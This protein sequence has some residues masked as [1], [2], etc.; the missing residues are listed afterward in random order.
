[1]K[2]I[3]ESSSARSLN[4]A[5][6]V[7]GGQEASAKKT[8]G[9]CKY[10]GWRHITADDQNFHQVQW[11]GE[12]I[13]FGLQKLSSSAIRRKKINFNANRYSR[14]IFHAQHELKKR[15][16][17]RRGE[18]H[19]VETIGQSQAHTAPYNPYGSQIAL[20]GASP[21]IAEFDSDFDYEFELW[22]HR[23][24]DFEFDYEFEFRFH[25]EFDFDFCYEFEF[26]FHCE[27]DFEFDGEFEFRFHC[28]SDFDFN[29]EFELWFI[30][31]MT[32]SLTSSSIMSLSYD[33]IMSLTS[34]SIMSL[35]FGFI[36]NFDFKFDSEFEFRFHCEYDLEFD[37]HIALR[38]S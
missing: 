38:V 6:V 18:V 3:Q 30:V 11:K 12:R 33:F 25:C 34:S 32:S 20:E 27:F 29:Y 2:P 36:V 28:E 4:E 22:F 15:E 5:P 24:F 16:A 1:M 21:R 10:K 13:I 9:T 14:A 26:R 19:N 35:S 17:L 7:V 31:S 37:G 8:S 23:Q